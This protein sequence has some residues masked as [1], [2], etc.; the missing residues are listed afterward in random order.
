VNFIIS[1]CIPSDAAVNRHFGIQVVFGGYAGRLSDDY[2]G[3]EFVLP[4][5]GSGKSRIRQPADSHHH[6]QYV[7]FFHDVINFSLLKIYE[8]HPL[9]R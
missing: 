9:W 4:N 3:A 7:Y 1:A 2:A 5:N 6:Q 8:V